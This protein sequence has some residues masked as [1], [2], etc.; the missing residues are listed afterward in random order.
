MMGHRLLVMGVVG[1]W[2]LM[3]ASLVRK[4]LVEVRPECLPGTY[5]SVLT[6]ER[7]NYQSR[8]GIFYE[9][10]DGRRRV[11]YTETV[12]LYRQDGRATIT[13]TTR[14]TKP[15]GGPLHRLLKFDLHS[16]VVVSRERELRRVRF[17]LDSP[18]GRAECRGEVA[19]GMLVLDVNAWGERASYQLPLPP[20]GMVGA[21]LSPLVA[22]PPL[23]VGL[24]WRV[25]VLSPLSFAPVEV[26]LE[27]LR[28]ERITWRG[29]EV[30]THVVEIHTGPFTTHAWVSPDGEV[31]VEKT[32]FKLVL[33]KEPVPEVG[34]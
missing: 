31:L 28:R 21:G 9:T 10:P 14:I 26:E 12:F 15:I 8:M 22:L 13:N 27:V 2:L 7:Q 24:R 4:W 33:V 1:F 30:E 16:S 6:P 3:T 19:G 32:P 23:R 18:V 20:G 5:R 29:K 11:G 25:A 34:D 17:V